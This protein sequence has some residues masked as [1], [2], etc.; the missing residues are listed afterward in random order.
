MSAARRKAGPRAPRRRFYDARHLVAFDWY[1]RVR[2]RCDDCG[3]C[4]PDHSIG[5]HDLAFFGLDPA[6]VLAEL[7]RQGMAVPRPALIA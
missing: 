1:G 3:E 5:W 6:V 4:W 2:R 7:A